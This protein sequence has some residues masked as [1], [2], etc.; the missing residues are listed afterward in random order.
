MVGSIRDA[1]RGPCAP[2]A[3]LI[4]LLNRAPSYDSYTH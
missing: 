2:L 1:N 4:S 3:A